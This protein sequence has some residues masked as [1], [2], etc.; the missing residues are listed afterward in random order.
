MDVCSY[1]YNILYPLWH[2]VGTVEEDDHDKPRTE[3]NIYSVLN[4]G[5]N[6]GC[7]VQGMS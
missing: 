7:P 4:W 2:I 6:F 1:V 3:E 5:L